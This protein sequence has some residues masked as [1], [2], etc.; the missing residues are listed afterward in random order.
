MQTEQ[1]LWLVFHDEGLSLHALMYTAAGADTPDGAPEE[2]GHAGAAPLLGPSSWWWD[3]RLSPEVC[4]VLSLPHSHEDE[5]T[6][7]LC[8][9]VALVPLTVAH[10]PKALLCTHSGSS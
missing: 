5:P 6:W 1:D 9:G 10:E 4:R 7:L 2:E 8:A 3:M